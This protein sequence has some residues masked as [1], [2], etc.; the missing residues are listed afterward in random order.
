MDAA[1]KSG[2]TL[3]AVL[4]VR[5][6]SQFSLMHLPHA[7]H[8]PFEEL[9]ARIGEVQMLAGASNANELLGA[10]AEAAGIRH[11]SEGGLGLDSERGG[12]GENERKMGDM[13]Y[14]LCRRGNNSQLAVARMRELGI[15]NAV[16]VVGGIENWA[17]SVDACMPVI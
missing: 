7:V 6:T 12:S 3:P 11:T 14:V 2:Q 13:L 5:P 9:E 17:R 16:D 8:I 4:D 10:Y 15:S 1:A